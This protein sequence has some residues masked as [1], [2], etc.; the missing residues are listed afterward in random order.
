MSEE[1]LQKFDSSL[2]Y[3]PA[4]IVDE[5]PNENQPSL[6]PS[7]EELT[8]LKAFE[9]EEIQETLRVDR[10]MHFPNMRGFHSSYDQTDRYRLRL[11][12]EKISYRVETLEHIHSGKK[13]RADLGAIAPDRSK[14]TWDSIALIICLAIQMAL[15]IDRLRKLFGAIDAF[16]GASICRYMKLAAKKLLPIYIYLIEQFAEQVAVVSGDDSKTRVLKMEE[17]AR[18]GFRESRESVDS[19]VAELEEKLG[20][21]FPRKDG[22]GHKSQINVSHLHGLTDQHNPRS[23]IYLFRTHFGSVGDFLSRILSLCSSKAKRKIFQGDLSSSNFPNKLSGKRWITGV[24]G[25]SVHARRPFFR[26]KEEDDRLCDR[27]LELFAMISAIEKQI[28]SEGRTP[29]RTRDYRQRLANPIWQQIIALAHSVL[30]AEAKGKAKNLLHFLWPKGSKLYQ[31]CQ[32]VVKHREA[33]TAY[34]NDYRLSANNNRAERLLRSE[35]ILLV[36]CKFRYSEEGR[37]VFDILRSLVMTAVAAS[38]DA[39]A[40]LC[41]VLKQSDDAIKANPHLYTPLAFHQ[42]QMKSAPDLQATRS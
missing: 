15:P 23:I 5:L 41:W 9:L 17:K 22:H 34:L 6:D 4:A 20:R 18:A 7:C 2:P 37:V 8:G 35:K 38:G 12:V 28:D 27:M 21:V 14:A 32:Y 19:M 1:Q 25:C 31:G 30:E 10:S 11:V 3:I 16:S 40:Y 33:L 24:A 36:S 39:K 13:L 26:F 29:T 42:M